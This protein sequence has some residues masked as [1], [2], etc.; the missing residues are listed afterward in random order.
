MVGLE[1]IHTPSFKFHYCGRITFFFSSLW[2]NF[3]SP[4]P[5]GRYVITTATDLAKNTRAQGKLQ[6][7]PSAL[8]ADPPPPLSPNSS[9]DSGGGVSLK[10]ET[11][12][13]LSSADS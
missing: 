12:E 7:P 3:Y 13:N 11:E 6:S 10:E 8:A 4:N 1:S 5:W 9:G 2:A